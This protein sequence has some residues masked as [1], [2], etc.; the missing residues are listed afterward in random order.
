MVKNILKILQQILTIVWPSV[1]DFTRLRSKGLNAIK[2][3]MIS[4]RSFTR[5]PF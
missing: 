1:S 2:V 4:I 5:K 3:I